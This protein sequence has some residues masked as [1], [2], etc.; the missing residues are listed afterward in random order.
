MGLTNKGWNTGERYDGE[1]KS[2]GL[3]S[4][5]P[6]QLSKRDFVEKVKLIESLMC[7]DILTNLHKDEEFGN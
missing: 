7:L 3:E 5:Q 6:G 2:L 1:G 4:N